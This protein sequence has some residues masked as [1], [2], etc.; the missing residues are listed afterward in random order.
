MQKP[1]NAKTNSD[2]CNEGNK[3]E[4]KIRKRRR[5]EVEEDSNMMVIKNRRAMARDR[6]RWT[7]AAMEYKCLQR[8]AAL[9]TKKQMSARARTIK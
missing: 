5:D 7:K 9:V 8:T 1:T 6:R 4:R 3:E 2:S